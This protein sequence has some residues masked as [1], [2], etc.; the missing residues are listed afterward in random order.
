M[1]GGFEAVLGFG[2]GVCAKANCAKVN[3][4]MK[5]TDVPKKAEYVRTICAGPLLKQATLPHLARK[6][7][8]RSG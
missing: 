5:M 6:T 3:E 1:G 2:L 8:P 7:R 4:E